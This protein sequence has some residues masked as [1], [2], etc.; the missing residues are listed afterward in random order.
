M[1]TL[2]PTSAPTLA[3]MPASAF[4]VVQKVFLPMAAIPCLVLGIAVYRYAM[5][6]LQGEEKFHKNMAWIYALVAGATLGRALFHSFAAASI[7]HYGLVALALLVGIAAMDLLFSRRSRVAHDNP[8]MV[9]PNIGEFGNEDLLI[10]HKTMRSNSHL[11]YTDPAQVG[12]AYMDARDVESVRKT[13]RHICYVALLVTFFSCVL[14]GI[15]LVYV[16]QTSYV[17][18]GGLV[19]ITYVDKL[20]ASIVM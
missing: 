9:T 8:R 20:L 19:G 7:V 1:S 13:R 4:S 3:A 2:A 17:D 18:T 15:T 5:R 12:V 10:N 16:Q 11:E 14:E 6:H